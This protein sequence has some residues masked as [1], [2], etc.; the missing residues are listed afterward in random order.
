[1]SDL[2]W[3]CLCLL[4]LLFHSEH[5]D[6]QNVLKGHNYHGK[7]NP[8]CLREITLSFVCQRRVCVSKYK[9]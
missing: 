4:G 3:K 2:Q 5:S 6:R 1:M 7:E 9:K 8:H